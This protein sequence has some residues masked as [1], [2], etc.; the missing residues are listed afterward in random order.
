MYHV[1]IDGWALPLAPT[2]L[3]LKFSNQNETINL[4]NDG[5][6]N[7]IKA[8]GLTDVSFDCILPA[9]QQYPMAYYPDGFRGAAYY[10]DKL[11]ELKAKKRTFTFLVVRTKQSNLLF[12]TELTCT[13]EDF[14]QTEDVKEGHDIVV[15]ISLK[16]YRTFGTKTVKIAPST[17]TKPATATTQAARATTGKPEVKTHTIKS[18]DTLWGIAKKY[19][20]NGSR[21]TEIYNLNKE[22]IEAEA[23]KRGYSSSQSGNRIWPKTVLIL[24]TDSG[25]SKA[26]TAKKMGVS[27]SGY[28]NGANKPS[29]SASRTNSIK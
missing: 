25:T 11:A 28:S 12:D 29:A 8:P 2:K 26:S 9:L 18:G 13:L 10:L 22:T 21:Y 1:Y 14:A 3:Q 16:Q 17:A 27:Q 24:P 20:G 6:V 7:I 19:L 5:E 23:K 4:I 15:S